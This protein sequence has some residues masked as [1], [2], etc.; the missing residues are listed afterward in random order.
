MNTWQCL[1]FG[2]AWLLAALLMGILI[3]I[4]LRGKRSNHRIGL[5]LILFSFV[6]GITLLGIIISAYS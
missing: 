1:V 4:G 5:L 2:I 3:R 6:C